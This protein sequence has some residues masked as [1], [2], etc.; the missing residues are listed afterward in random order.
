MSS[1]MFRRLSAL[2][3][4][5]GVAL[6]VVS[7]NINPGPPANATP[8]QL[9]A[10]RDQYFT[11]ILWGAWLQAVG[12]LLI[13]LFAFALVVLAGAANRLSGLMTILGGIVLLMVSLIEVSFFLSATFSPAAA[14]AQASLVL[15]AAVQHLYFIVAAPTLFIAL[16]SVILGSSL[17]SRPFGYVAMALGLAFAVIGLATLFTPVLPGPVQAA[18]GV[19]TLWWVAAAVALIL[20]RDKTTAS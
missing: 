2:S 4:I 1:F 5:L 11:S 16:G 10:F 9:V 3:G 6:L 12:P 20:K 18:A 19:Q 13:V 17:L 15:I 14:I 7:F 8:E